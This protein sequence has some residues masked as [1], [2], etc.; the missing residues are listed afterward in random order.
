LQRRK[1][2]NEIRKTKGNARPAVKRKSKSGGGTGR[3]GGYTKKKEKSHCYLKERNENKV[4]GSK[5]Q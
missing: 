1:N 4:V 5:K 2:V 3:E